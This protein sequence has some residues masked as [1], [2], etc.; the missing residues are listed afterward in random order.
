MPLF[1]RDAEHFATVDRLPVLPLRD[2][3]I[4]PYVVIPLLVGRPTSLA[5]L[6]AAEA[7]A[8][9]GKDKFVLLV[10]QRSGETQDPAAGDLYRVG[11]VAR[12]LQNSRLPNG[13]AK[14]LVEG[15]ARARVTRYAPA[16]GWLRAAV[17]PFPLSPAGQVSGVVVH[18]AGAA[19]ES[20][21][22][23]PSGAA[24]RAGPDESGDAAVSRQV[25][26]RFEEYVSLHRRIP[27]ETT[28]FVQAIESDERRAIAVAAG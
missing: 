17:E 27:D 28:A 20:P 4:F 6:D 11:V 15:I 10:A 16:S 18:P 14:V 12:V 13:T 2:V 5:A 21:A 22:D 3:V 24:A 8:G 25:A 23:E 19:A 7:A 9:P 1:S 26:S